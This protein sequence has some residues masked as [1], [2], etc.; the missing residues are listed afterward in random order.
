MVYLVAKGSREQL[1][2]LDLKLLAEAI[3]RPHLYIVGA[4]DDTPLP[5]ERQAALVAALLAAVGDDLRIDELD[6]AVLLGTDVDNS[7]AAKNS[8]LRRGKPHSVS[9]VHS[10]RHIV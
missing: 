5:G 8:H 10:L 1:L 6:D 7:H 9:A 3:L 2:A 4:L